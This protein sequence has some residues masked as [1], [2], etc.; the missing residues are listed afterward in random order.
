MKSNIAIIGSGFSDLAASCYLAKEGNA[1]TIYEKNSG[2][3]GRARQFRKQGFTFDMGPTWYWMPDVFER[4]FSDFDKKPS[5]YYA[6]Q[7]L[8]PAYRVYFGDGDY[9]T[10]GDTLDKIIAAF[11]KEEAGSSEKLKT[12]IAQAQDNY[13]IAI[14]DLVYRPGVTP[15]ELITVETAKKIGQFFR[16]ISKEVRSEFTNTRLI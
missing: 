6:L 7:K 4:F 11:E 1:V 16:T 2:I 14:K 9:I 12:F 13:N 3:G 5:D 10:I 8:D 15:L